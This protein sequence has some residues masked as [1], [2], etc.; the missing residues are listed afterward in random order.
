MTMRRTVDYSKPKYKFRGVP[1]RDRRKIQHLIDL[2]ERQA[3][4]GRRVRIEVENQRNTNGI[5]L[6]WEPATQAVRVERYV[7]KSWVT[8]HGY[9]GW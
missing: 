8:A 4:A 7:T 3:K 5:S 2:V 6:R 9:R 1:A